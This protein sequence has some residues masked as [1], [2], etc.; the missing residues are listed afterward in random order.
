MIK[1]IHKIN[2]LG[3][4]FSNFTWEATLPEFKKCN[5]IY[6][7]NGCGKTTLTRLFDAIS[8]APTV[9]PEYD[10]EDDA[11]A[12]H[13]NN[14]AYPKEIRVFN[15]D[16]VRENIAVIEGKTSSISIL[17][18]AENKE[19]VEK[20]EGDKKFL[21]GDPD[22]EADPGKV[23]TLKTKIESKRQAEKAKDG[24]FTDVA[25]TIGAAVGGNALRDYRKPQAERD[26]SLL[27]A[28]EELSSDQLEINL[29]AVKQESMPE[30]PL[31][32]VSGLPTFNNV[33]ATDVG[34]VVAALQK[35]ATTLLS[36]TV[37][38]E[39]LARLA[40]YPKIA[41]WVEQGIH[42][43]EEHKSEV[44]EY[45]L[46]KIP[47]D[48]ISQLARHFNDA[49][50]ALK[51]ELGKLIGWLNAITIVVS[52]LSFPDKNRF[53]TELQADAEAAGTAFS[54]AK[55]QLQRVV[56]ELINEVENKKTQTT[57]AIK[58]VSILDSQPLVVALASINGIITAHN[59]KTKDFEKVK[60]AATEKLKKH[61]LSAIFD[62]VKIYATTIQ[63][64]TQDI[65]Q[66]TKE[67]EEIR[68][69]IKE[70]TA[71][72]SSD[73]KA[74]E[75]LTEK[76]K[77][78]LG[79]NELQFV[80]DNSG[81]DG[82]IAGYKIMRGV[83]P[84]LGLSEGEK[85]AIAFVYFLV[86]L[87]DQTFNIKE[88]IVVIDDPISSLDSASLYQAFS[89]LKNAVLDAGQVFIFTHS[90][91]F[92]RLLINWR[93]RP[94]SQRANSGFYMVKNKYDANA[95]AGYLT[96]L[97]KELEKYESEY[98]YL[99]KLLKEFHAEQNDSIARAY[100]IPNIAR[101]VWE[102]FLLFAVPNSDNF[103]VK[104]NILKESGHDAQKLDAIYK[105]TND[106]SHVTGSG[107]D[108]SLV[109]EA[110][111]VTKE[112]FEMMAAVFPQH[113]KILDAA[114]N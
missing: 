65:E 75:L 54:S 93:Q 25:K 45:C 21:S 27:E 55:A 68:A 34:A 66:L 112:L 95:R 1:K 71:K 99:F 31:G 3:L 32:Q 4:V 86:H 38:S 17:L 44:C 78:F 52:G 43:H 111:K 92:L 80:P 73:E 72:I 106:Q 114:T 98:Q 79:H 29:A 22:N 57:Q 105:F 82:A 101:K 81:T 110:K 36:R 37:E 33:D 13:K 103:Y 28:K 16:Y 15:S 91:D 11:G 90:F 14:A 46:Q 26:F 97:D 19:L 10:V 70:N 42:L 63:T 6:G 20:I 85:T 94:S 7:W 40:K 23:S 104:M 18:G 76:L 64:L 77:T 48:R 39:I 51:S 59:E 9:F 47:A 5:L 83:E 96:K 24:K 67:V 107:F 50:K 102:T 41:L 61:Y 87:S 53:Y 100:P 58:V 12:R 84:A 69:R 49:D 113:Y 60:R 62:D 35:S 109:P 8:A 74:C 56:R 30:V 2:G 89:F 88:G 108:P